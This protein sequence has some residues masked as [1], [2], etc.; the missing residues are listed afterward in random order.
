MQLHF[1]FIFEV[2]VLNKATHMHIYAE[3][4]NIWVTSAL[5]ML[6]RPTDG[7][8][9]SNKPHLFYVKGGALCRGHDD[10]CVQGSSYSLDTRR[11]YDVESTSMT[12][13]QRRS[14]VVCPVVYNDTMQCDTKWG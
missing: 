11:C 9:E 7:D 14:N 6:N 8:T 5:N 3:I 4:L 12:L 13:I 10:L 2:D 1:L